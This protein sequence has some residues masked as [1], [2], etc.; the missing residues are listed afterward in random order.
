MIKSSLVQRSLGW[1]LGGFLCLCGGRT[2]LDPWVVTSPASAQTQQNTFEI[3]HRLEPQEEG[4][5][6]GS[7]LEGDDGFI[8]GIVWS[9]YSGVDRQNLE[10]LARLFRLN[11]DS[12][13]LSYLHDFDPD[14]QGM[15]VAQGSP[16]HEPR[17]ALVKAGVGFYG[18]THRLIGENQVEGRLMEIVPGSSFRQ[19]YSFDG[20]QVGLPRGLVPS[21]QGDHFYG[22]TSKGLIFKA[23]PG[24]SLSFLYHLEP[25][26]LLNPIDLAVDA[27][28]NINGIA[29]RR[30]ENA[31]IDGVIF[32]ISTEGRLSILAQFPDP[33]Q[34]MPF[35]LSVDENDRHYGLTA[36]R[37]YSNFG[38]GTLAAFPQSYS[39]NTSLYQIKPGESLAP[40][41]PFFQVGHNPMIDYISVDGDLYGYWGMRET[42]PAEIVRVDP[43]G[44]V[45][46]LHSFQNR[47]APRSQLVVTEDGDL[48]GTYLDVSDSRSWT[49]GIFRLGSP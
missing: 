49:G 9:D 46:R 34:Q 20:E 31:Q 17:P 39:E 23:T 28:G 47:I 1:V 18:I 44:Q 3:I 2:A 35:G 26:G 21:P 10:A 38:L 7:L 6:A 22:Y 19:I 12:R 45:T 32:Q 27:A 37:L 29:L 14:Q 43:E 30:D 36:T 33:K 42:A 41:Y 15:L 24:Q 5:F 13:E 40:L 25:L 16:L 11:P 8:Y 4:S 48:F